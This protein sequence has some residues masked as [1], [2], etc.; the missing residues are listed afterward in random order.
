M[1]TLARIVQKIQ[2]NIGFAC[3][4]I[5]LIAIMIQVFCR[6]AGVTVIWTGEV[7]TYAFIWSV[8]MGAGVMTYENKHFSFDFL[9]SAITGRKK[10][11][12][13]LLTAF[14]MLLFSIV[15][16]YFGLVISKRFWNYTW[17]T[18]P[19]IKM[20]YTWLCIPIFGATSSIYVLRNIIRN[21]YLLL[22]EK[23]KTKKI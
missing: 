10:I 22:I 13:H 15:L 20:G 23:T 16:F 2:L 4:T 9:A 17:I 14:I 7:S 18:I 11:F 19:A 3:I 1:N 21:L 8:F 5:F 6:Y 12:L